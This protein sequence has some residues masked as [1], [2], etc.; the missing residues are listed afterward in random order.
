MLF[1]IL[2]IVFICNLFMMYYVYKAFS[3][4]LTYY[5]TQNKRTIMPNVQQVLGEEIRR[6]AKKE[7]RAAIE[8]L[9]E[10]IATLKKTVSEQGK[11]L[12]EL[13]KLT[14]KTASIVLPPEEPKDE[15]PPE[16]M[17]A[18]RVSPERIIKWRKKIGVSQTQFAKLLGVSHLS[19]NHW[20]SGKTEPRE[21]Q[22]Q[23]IVELRDM[24]KRELK[25]LIFERLGEK[26]A[27][28]YAKLA[29]KAKTTN[30]EATE[31]TTEK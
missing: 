17:K 7:A 25:A 9:K 31:E 28:R 27:K 24:G 21:A 8:D 23:R 30:E 3:L 15:I 10:Q 22:K 2:F 6:L 13:S 14:N 11:L 1:R 19:V 20:E 12:K 4:L 26:F 16:E 5:F 18:V 29:A